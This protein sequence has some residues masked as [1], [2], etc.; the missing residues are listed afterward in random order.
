VLADLGNHL[1]EF[2]KRL[3]ENGVQV[4]WATTGEETNAKVVEIAHSNKV[5]K[6]V[7]SKSM[8]TEEIHLNAS[9][10]DAGVE[11]VETDLGEYIVQLAD[12]R[13]SHIIAPIIHKSREDVGQVMHERLGVPFSDDPKQLAR[14]A[15][16]K[17]RQDFLAA[18][19]GVTGAN[20]GVV[21]TGT[22]CIVTNEGNARMVTSLPRIH[23]VVMGIEKLL[24]SLLDLD[25]FLKLLARSATGQKLS[26]YTTLVQGPRKGREAGPEQVHVVLLDNGRSSLLGGDL[27]ESLACIRCGAC[28]N[29]CPIYRNIG[30]H[31]YGDTYAGPIGSII[32]PGLRGLADWSELPAASTLCGACREICPVRIDIP[33]MLLRLRQTTRERLTTPITLKWAMTGFGVAAALPPLYRLVTGMARRLVRHLGK[34]GWI[35]YGFPPFKNWTKVRDFKT[36]APRSFQQMWQAKER[37]G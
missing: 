21:E 12:D 37:A 25:L 31:A 16:E 29:V 1:L 34:D 32:T 5:T 26:V 18:D 4:H 27:A 8:V 2:E 22:V 28:L 19:M 9:L 23:V 17:L 30:G 20:F 35:K 11:V 24:P 6:V 10:I 3:Q 36:P 15:R 7:K 33:R 14:I 13:P